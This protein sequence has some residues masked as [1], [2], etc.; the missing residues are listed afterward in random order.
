MGLNERRFFDLIK[1]KHWPTI[2]REIRDAAGHDVPID[3]DWD[4]YNLDPNLGEFVRDREKPERMAAYLG[5]VFR[6]VPDALREVGRDP[7]GKD[8]IRAGLKRIQFGCQKDASARSTEYKHFRDG[9]L[10]Y[11]QTGQ[12]SNDCESY[13]KIV[14]KELEDGL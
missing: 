2:E 14:V 3:V 11:Q 8:A 4:S 10:T 12:N 1:E 6:V 9:V 5:V 13:K 7:A